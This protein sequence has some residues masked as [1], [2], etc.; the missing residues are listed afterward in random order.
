MGLLRDLAAGRRVETGVLLSG[1]LPHPTPFKMLREVHSVGRLGLLPEP[2]PHALP[3]SQLQA[4]FPCRSPV[5][6]L[7]GLGHTRPPRAPAFCPH[8][9]GPLLFSAVRCLHHTAAPPQ[10]SFAVS[11]SP[12]NPSAKT[13]GTSTVPTAAH[14]VVC[15]YSALNK[16]LLS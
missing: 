6:G 8:Y 14:T 13:A 12:W 3:S 9:G 11:C 4:S 10:P 1:P 15:M 16:Y 2:G 5:V 7:Q